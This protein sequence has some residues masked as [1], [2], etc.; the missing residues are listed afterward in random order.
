M[1]VA[2]LSPPASPAASVALPMPVNLAVDSWFSLVSP[3]VP[4]QDRGYAWPDVEC[5]TARAQPD[6]LRM[7]KASGSMVLSHAHSVC[8]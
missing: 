6:E 8:S 2:H 1:P 4:R 5:D 7:R 3:F